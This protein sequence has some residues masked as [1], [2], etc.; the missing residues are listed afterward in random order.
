MRLQDQD[1]RFERYAVIPRTLTF[2]THGSEVLFLRGAPDK[3]L[4]AGKLNGV[5]GHVEPGEDILAAAKREILE[6][7]GLALAELHL[8]ALIHIDGSRALGVLLF[9]YTGQAP[10]GSV[11]PSR[12]GSL[13]WC[14]RHSLPKAD[15]VEDLPHL[16]PRI[17]AQDAPDRLIYGHYVPGP[18]GQYIFHFR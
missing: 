2:L 17:L 7:T 15:L 9:V 14:N 12:E 10:S 11:H 1:A 8:R 4:W 3:R 6:E 5:G 18:D 13:V 16:L